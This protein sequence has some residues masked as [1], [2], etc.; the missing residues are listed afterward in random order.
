MSIENR[1]FSVCTVPG[2]KFP[3]HLL[4]GVLLCVFASGCAGTGTG[5]LDP[6]EI[7][8]RI[9]SIKSLVILPPQ[10]KMTEISAGGT[11][12]EMHEWSDQ[13]VR[14]L[15][16]ALIQ[17]FKNRQGVTTSTSATT[18]SEPLETNVRET[19]ALLM[20]IE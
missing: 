8:D 16:A 12:E 15:H 19:R 17:E 1:S 9:R 6:P 11:V 18:D 7:G 10:I 4:A 5:V 20:A 13:A 2:K 14:N 3:Q